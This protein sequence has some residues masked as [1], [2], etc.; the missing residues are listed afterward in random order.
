M[1]TVLLSFVLLPKVRVRC[2][3]SL[4]HDTHD[5]C[6]R[7]ARRAIC[8]CPQ[9]FTALHAI[10]IASAFLGFGLNIRD[11][12]GANGAGNPGSVSIGAGAASALRTVAAWARAVLPVSLRP[13]KRSGSDD[14]SSAG[15]KGLQLV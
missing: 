6:A 11:K 2:A 3:A 13:R 14:G 12:L 15:G 10:A 4:L 7:R 8:L 5:C 1:A 9:P